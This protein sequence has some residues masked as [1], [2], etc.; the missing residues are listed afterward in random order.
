MV[1]VVPQGETSE[2]PDPVLQ[3]GLSDLVVIPR[4][5]GICKEHFLLCGEYI[6]FFVHPCVL[7]LNLGK[8]PSPILESAGS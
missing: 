1:M 6:L 8:I 3:R 7:I 2:T 5:G 4:L